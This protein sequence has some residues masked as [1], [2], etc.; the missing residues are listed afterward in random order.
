[1]NST[2]DTITELTGEGTD[3]VQSSVTYTLGSNIENLTL[4]GSSNISGTGNSLD[5]YLLGNSGSNTLTGGAG[6]D[7]LSGGSGGDRMEGGL[8]DDT[9][10]VAQSGDVVIENI[11]EGTDTVQSSITY[12]LGNHLENLTLTGT[13]N[14]HGTGNT[15]NNYLT[16][17][18]GANSLTGGA[19]HDTLDGGA[20]NDTLIG[21][22]GD[23]TY[24]VNVTTDVITESG[25]GLDTVQSAVTWTLGSNLENL[26]LTGTS[27]INGTGNSLNNWITGNSAAN[28]LSGAA[29]DDTLDGGA[30]VDTLVGGTGNDSYIVDST[31]DTITENTGEGT[32]TVLSSVTYTLGSNLENLTLTGTAAIS[33]TGNSL[34]NQLTGNSG[35][36]SLSGA[37]GDDVLDGAAGS[38]TLAGGLGDDTYLLN[39]GGGTDSIQESGGFDLVRFGSST[40]TSDV[41]FFSDDSDLDIGYSTSDYAVVVN[42]SGSSSKVDRFELDSGL[43]LTADEVNQVI[44][45]MAAYAAANSISFTSITDVQ[46]SQDLMNIIASSWHS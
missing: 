30:G 18:S 45:E 31:T 36:N 4:T 37:D 43:Y 14:I 25:T 38:D 10:I 41:A 9:Y 8:G 21:G 22:D 19:G 27:S 26:T 5:N 17:N 6:N 12:T 34:N 29:G 13:N 3:T 24:I 40:T 7:T 33:G 2:T 23:D 20:G 46:A 1:V 42:Q 11:N 15:L 16:G 35:A 39:G 32:D 44:Q 28:S